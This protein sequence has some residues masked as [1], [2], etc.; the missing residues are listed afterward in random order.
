MT[1]KKLYLSELKGVPLKKYKPEVLI[2]VERMKYPFTGLY[3]YC[4]HLA[5][6]LNARARDK[7]RFRFI[8]PPKMAFPF[9]YPVL[10]KSVIKSPVKL[11]SADYD[12]LHATWQLSKFLPRDDAA[13]VLTIHDLN[14]LYTDKSSRKK[15]KILKKI[16]QRIDRA[17]AVIAISEFVKK[18]ILRH[19]HPR[20]TPVHVIYNGVE[21]KEY[22]DF[23][24]PRF[25]PQQ[26]FLFAMGTVLPKKNFHVLPA[27]LPSTSFSLVIAGIQPDK[28]YAEKI[29]AE[30]RRYGVQDRVHLTGP[31]TDEEKYWYLSRSEAFL[32]PSL[33]EGFGMP[34]VEAMRLGK[35]VFLSRSTSLP[36][37]GGD[38][39]YYFDNFDADRMREVLLRG[40]EDYKRRNRSDEIKRHSMKFTWENAVRRYAEI[41]EDVCRKRR[42]GNH[43]SAGPKITAI[44]PTY[45]EENNI[46]DAIKSVEWA[47]EIL[48][49]DSYSTDQTV[50]LARQ[51]GAKVIQRKFDNFSAQKNYAID[52]ASHE[53]IFL[54]DADER[55][56]P[57]LRN[58]IMT[59]LRKGPQAVAYWI[60]RQNFLGEKKIRFS[61]WQHDRCIRLFHKKH[62]RYNGRFVHEEIEA[63]G[64]VGM[65]RNKLVHFTYRSEE[66][67]NRKMEMY[68][69]L[70][71]KEWLAGGKRY[72]PFLQVLTS[73]YRFFRHYILHL[74]FLDGKAGWKIAVNSMK[75]VWKRYENL[76]KLEKS[77][78]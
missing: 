48:V 70:K 16:R 73:A 3:Y 45:N 28:A 5:K 74:G 19:L 55:V 71:A 69:R 29:L 39:A 40:L 60:P 23:D 58:E 78:T 46:A 75:T 41:Y 30:A 8:R 67:F 32:F 25:R 42:C 9:D 51:M 59:V 77:A 34:P 49:I 15:E 68:A 31:V 27:L 57:R 36:E 65:L 64:K 13:Y 18:D 43:S 54:L 2:D 7:F 33:S 52:K 11:K 38:V 62:A 56:T 20:N 14:F 61:G 6:N 50:R 44:I 76:R 17:D 53:W 24:T 22:P 66:Q 72:N 26:P 12:I 1:R 35:P 4:Y 10:K 37:I 63:D 47:D 21:V